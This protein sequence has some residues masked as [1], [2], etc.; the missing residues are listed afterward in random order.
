M[1]Y[2][3]SGQRFYSLNCKGFLVLWYYLSTLYSVGSGLQENRGGLWRAP[4]LFAILT[5]GYLGK[6]FLDEK[7]FCT[8]TQFS[9][10]AVQEF[11]GVK[12]ICHMWVHH[13][14][15]WS[16]FAATKVDGCQN[17]PENV[18]QL[19]ADL[20]LLALTCFFDGQVNFSSDSS[21]MFLIISETLLRSTAYYSLLQC[22]VDLWH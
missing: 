21:L 22:G 3:Y 8:L 14:K 6:I 15:Y 16:I 5:I 11:I 13:P 12:R 19:L 7:N 10:K 9:C 17:L 20:S 4:L 1:L 2:L 18:C